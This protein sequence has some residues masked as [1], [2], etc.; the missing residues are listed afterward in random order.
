MA[1]SEIPSQV[2]GEVTVD[3]IVDHFV[4]YVKNDNLGQISSWLLA[5]LDNKG[6]DCSECIELAKACSTAVDFAKTG[7]PVQFE[8]IKRLVRVLTKSY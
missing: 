6:A 4:N 2:H 8:S 3:H 7:V 5:H 1:V